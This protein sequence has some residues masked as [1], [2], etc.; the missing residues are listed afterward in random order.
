[1]NR[2]LCGVTLSSVDKGNLKKA[3]FYDIN[4]DCF[5]KI[6]VI[7]NR[8]NKIFNLK[9]NNK[10]LINTQRF[11]NY[12]INN[13]KNGFVY[14]FPINNNLFYKLNKIN[15]IDSLNYREIAKQLGIE[16]WTL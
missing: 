14:I 13:F 7:N 5:F 1:M 12:G 11:F 9:F 15:G 8:T 10:Y 4:E 6:N 16:E 3:G 2:Y